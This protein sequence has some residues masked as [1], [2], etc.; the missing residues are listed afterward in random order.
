MNRVF[1]SEVLTTTQRMLQLQSVVDNLVESNAVLERRANSASAKAK[2]YKRELRHMHKAL[3][4]YKLELR[5]LQRR[6]AEG[7]P[8]P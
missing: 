8:S 7:V 5:E 2:V 4:L 3:R 6:A 1:Q